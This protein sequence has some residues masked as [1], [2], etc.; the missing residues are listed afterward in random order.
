M[1]PPVWKWGRNIAEKLP[2]LW[3]VLSHA[4]HTDM[5]VEAYFFDSKAEMKL[6]RSVSVACTTLKRD[7]NSVL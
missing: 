1:K 5:D 4:S 6:S 2:Y 3:A 7:R